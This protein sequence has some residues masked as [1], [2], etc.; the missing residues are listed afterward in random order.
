MDVCFAFIYLGYRMMSLL[1]K[2]ETST[3]IPL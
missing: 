3:G 2:T 1:L